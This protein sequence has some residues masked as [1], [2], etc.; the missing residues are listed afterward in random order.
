[1]MKFTEMRGLF[2][3]LPFWAH[4]AVIDTPCQVVSKYNPRI[5]HI[6]YNHKTAFYIYDH[7]LKT[8]RFTVAKIGPFKN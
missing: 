2:Q 5:I 4:S 6:K 1:M 7:N 8:R 3:D